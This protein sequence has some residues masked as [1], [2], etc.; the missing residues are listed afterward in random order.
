[1]RFTSQFTLL[2]LLFLNANLFAADA[3]DN[4]P[5]SIPKVNLV[6]KE[7]VAEALKSHSISSTKIVTAASANFDE[8]ESDLDKG[9]LKG[10]IGVTVSETS[11]TKSPTEVKL[12]FDLKKISPED[13]P[14]ALEATLGLIF[15]SANSMP[16][17]QRLVTEYQRQFCRKIAKKP[18]PQDS[19]LLVLCSSFTAID[20][21]NS[22]E[23]VLKLW[24]S[25]KE[26]ALAEL[27]DAIA[28]LEKQL[29]EATDEDAKIA[30]TSSIKIVKAELAAWQ[31][32][33]VIVTTKKPDG[34]LASVGLN[35]ALEG[36]NSKGES[37]EYTLKYF[38]IITTP[39]VLGIAV[40]GGFS[41]LNSE[42]YQTYKEELRRQLARIAD[43]DVKVK[44]E[45][46][47]EIVGLMQFLILF[48]SL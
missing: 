39:R 38:T 14:I 32:R 9:K 11:W 33:N 6:L 27:P 41:N 23:D 22:I 5:V 28:T 15:D 13:D 19:M 16:H 4:K 3:T 29:A 20:S 44:A 48:S 47:E 45:L 7:V 30:L 37:G 26:G 42:T 40:N 25:V 8:A 2:T 36:L 46:Q 35:I 31:E 10:S 43:A 21:Y 12:T 1:M 24:Q 18:Q 34:T 17:V